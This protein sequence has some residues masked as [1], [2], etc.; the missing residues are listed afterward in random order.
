MENCRVNFT[1]SSTS[2]TV[3]LQFTAL[4]LT[5]R[6]QEAAREALDEDKLEDDIKPVT[7]PPLSPCKPKSK[8]SPKR[9]ATADLSRRFP[10]PATHPTQERRV[11][12]TEFKL[13]VLSHMT[14]GRVDD[15][16]GS[17]R[18]PRAKEVCK[19]YSLGTYTE[20]R[21]C[22]SPSGYM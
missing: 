17:L 2:D 8:P 13:G 12:M 16:K 1:M 21:V 20:I 4:V 11:F 10:P 9:Q 5:P 19:R 3:V 18:A 6:I 22:H 14:Y 15:G 7:H